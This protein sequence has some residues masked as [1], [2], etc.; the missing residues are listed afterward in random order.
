LGGEAFLD[1]LCRSGDSSFHIVRTGALLT[2]LI[3]DDHPLVRAALALTV[4]NAGLSG[5]VLTARD[6]TEAWA[7][8]ERE[9]DIELCLVDLHMPGA[10][11]ADGLRGVRKRAPVAKIVVITG[12]DRDEELLEALEFGV[13]GFVPKSANS[14]IVGAALKLVMAGGRYLPPRLA[15]I[16][17]K[18]LPHGAGESSQAFGATALSD[19]EA[20]FGRV[21]GRQLEVLRLLAEGR[22]NKEIARTLSLSPAT[23]K[24]HVAQV[25]AALGATNRTEAVAKARKFGLLA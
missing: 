15:E 3:C 14:G 4:E 12:S 23:V 22:S 5:P 16:I 18:K 24:S 11:P 21:T 10:T 7:I 13:D 17:S 20:S 19:T 9:P 1:T 8:A 6:F 25:I 2:I